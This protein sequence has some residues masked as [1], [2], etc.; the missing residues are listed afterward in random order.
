MPCSRGGLPVRY[1]DCAVQVTAGNAGIMRASCPLARKALIR[2]ESGP[3]NP[4]VKPTTLMTA[5]RC[6]PA[7]DKPYELDGTVHHKYITEKRRCV[8]VPQQTSLRNKESMPL[9]ST[10][11]TP[12]D[13]HST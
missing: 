13:D 3:S 10:N 1:V 11:V 4:S 2:G 5:E 9:P 6:I 8:S 12:F 7:C